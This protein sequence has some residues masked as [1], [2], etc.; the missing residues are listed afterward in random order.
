LRIKKT[1]ISGYFKILKFSDS[2][3]KEAQ[4]NAISLKSKFD[5]FGSYYPQKFFSNNSFSEFKDLSIDSV[6]R[7]KEC[8][9]CTEKK[10]VKCMSNCCLCTKCFDENNSY[11]MD[12]ELALT[13][14]SLTD[15]KKFFI[16]PSN[17]R[18][19]IVFVDKIEKIDPSNLDIEDVTSYYSA[20][21]NFSIEMAYVGDLSVQ[22]RPS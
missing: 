3:E 12:R 16:L 11:N 5:I 17:D 18:I 14:L 2:S 21:L 7:D 4:S 8:K 15:L 22:N 9:D 6:F 13:I 1:K 20:L 19:I 10:C